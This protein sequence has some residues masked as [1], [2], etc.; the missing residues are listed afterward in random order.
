MLSPRTQGLRSELALRPLPAR[1]E[2]ADSKTGGKRGIQQLPSYLGKGEVFLTQGLPGHFIVG[3]DTMALTTNR[4]LLGFREIPQGAHFL[5]VQQPTGVSRCGY[6]FSTEAQTALR[7]KQW[8]T[9]NETLGEPSQAWAGKG[10]GS[11]KSVYPNLQPYGLH[12]HRDI[13][14]MPLEGT[15]PEWAR[16]PG[17]LWHA[18]T[19][20]VSA[21]TLE[22]ITVRTDV[23]EYLVDSMD[24]AKDTFQ[25]DARSSGDSPQIT[26]INSNL[27]FLFTQDFRDLQVL[28]LGPIQSRV[29]DTSLRVQS[30]L[31]ASINS[32]TPITEDDILAEMQFTFLTGTH[33]GNPACL[34]QW[35]NLVLKIVLRAYSLAASRPKLSR[36][37]IQT[38]HAQL[39]YTEHYVGSFTAGPEE[40]K[41][42]GQNGLSSDD[43]PIFEYK[44]QNKDKL[45]RGL[46]GYKRR[47]NDMVLSGQLGQATAEQQAVSRTFEELESWLWRRG[48]DLSGEQK[49]E[50]EMG[51]MRVDD[52]DEEEDEQPVVVELDEEGREVGLI[53]FRD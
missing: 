36:G 34:E 22:R 3:L 38:L 6:W 15:H 44:P 11:V 31:N 24:C 13:P 25:T 10:E 19:S 26:G 4:S 18:L 39:F 48:W 49:I 23:K 17:N 46:A 29:A 45:Y 20:A 28:D 1:S 53:S 50:R 33:L 40:D 8:D 35:W 43:R 16:S 7:I 27:N 51:G 30:L 47:L 9:Q 32:P 5:W 21:T 42:V 41:G 52:S 37:L 12:A 2:D 14:S